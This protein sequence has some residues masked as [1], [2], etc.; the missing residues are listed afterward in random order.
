MFE[1]DGL[2]IGGI[3]LSFILAI[4][5]AALKTWANRYEEGHQ[6]RGTNRW[7]ADWKRKRDAEIDK[8]PIETGGKDDD[9]K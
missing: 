9:T 7:L 4:A 2:C 8:L 5:L 6:V 3:V 1:L